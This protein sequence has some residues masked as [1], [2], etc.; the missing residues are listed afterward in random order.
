MKCYSVKNNEISEGIDVAGLP[1]DAS[2]VGAG[3]VPAVMVNAGIPERDGVYPEQV[4]QDSLES[5]MACSRVVFSKAEEDTE[6]RFILAYDPREWIPDRESGSR[7]VIVYRS[8]ER[9]LA[10]SLEDG[11]FKM[12]NIRT[13]QSIVD[14]EGR[15]EIVETKDEPVE[16]P[17]PE[18]GWFWATMQ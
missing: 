9:F 3:I 6:G 13:S 4:F 2:L 12:K 7:L 18:D 8:R 16:L 11:H 14:K 17:D 10:M 15:P 1:C 5:A